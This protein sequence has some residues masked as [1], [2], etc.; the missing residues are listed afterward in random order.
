MHMDRLQAMKVFEQV[1]AEN[2][3]AAAGRKL[4]L[5]PAVVTR[6]IQE[7]EEHLDVRL[8]QRST[9]R[10]A[11]TAAGQDY[12][13]RV[14]RILADIDDAELAAN[15]HMKQMSGVV[16]VSALPA[17]ASHLVAP[18][19]ADFLALQPQVRVELRSDELANRHIE[20]Y[21]LTVLTDQ[22]D[23]PS[24]VVA[25]RL[26]QTSIVL[27]A[28]PMY[29]AKAGLPASPIELTAHGFIELS[30]P[31]AK[32]GTLRLQNLRES[33]AMTE[34]DL[35]PVFCSNDH[36][37]VLR[38]TLAG[39][40]ISVQAIPVIAPMLRAGQLLRVLP[41]WVLQLVELRVAYA[42]RRH[43]PKRTRAFMEHLIAHAKRT[44]DSVKGAQG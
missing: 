1:V 41:E 20:E 10:L 13:E 30:L 29:A 35:K 25:R 31:N 7:L 27:C 23:L 11:L 28:S 40:G 8:L 43:M 37:A 5:S 3:F 34:V 17:L 24:A 44:E 19:L 9:R 36:D 33:E 26:A 22:F 42:S 32:N 14:Q 15:S 18:A 4:S 6:L 12:L 38:A 39:A 2:G 16:R 21:D